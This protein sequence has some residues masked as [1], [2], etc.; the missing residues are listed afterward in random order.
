VRGTAESGRHPHVANNVDVDGRGQI[1]IV[2]RAKAGMHILQ[3]S[4]DA[5]KIAGLPD[6][7]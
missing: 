7:G 1:S 2:D 5:R 3:L 4:G 6:D